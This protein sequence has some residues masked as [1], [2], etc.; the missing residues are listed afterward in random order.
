MKK[1][2]R[3]LSF[4]LAA[5]LC[6]GLLAVTGAASDEAAEPAEDAVEPIEA[7][8]EASVEP[9]AEET[10]A[11]AAAEEEGQKESVAPSIE[12]AEETTKKCSSHFLARAYTLRFS[13][14]RSSRDR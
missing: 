6:L 5:V 3:F 1:S 8:E 7:A 4:I 9:A 12:V 10:S 2:T 11:E 13:S 14:T